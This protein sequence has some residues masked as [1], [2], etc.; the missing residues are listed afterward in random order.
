MNDHVHPIF[1]DILNG[2]QILE[3]YHYTADQ[4]LPFEDSLLCEASDL[5]M[6]EYPRTIWIDGKRFDRFGQQ[7]SG[8]GELE[9]TMYRSIENEG[10][11]PTFVKIF[12]D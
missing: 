12:N 7:K 4:F 1:R 11:A 8:E 10:K 2:A 5:E 3:P 9:C 6:N